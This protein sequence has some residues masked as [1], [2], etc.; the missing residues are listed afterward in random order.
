MSQENEN[1]RF[2]N[3]EAVVRIMKMKTVRTSWRITCYVTWS[4]ETNFILSAIRTLFSSRRWTKMSASI[5][6]SSEACSS[7]LPMSNN[8]TYETDLYPKITPIVRSTPPLKR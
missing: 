4:M 3:E 2:S 8:I 7:R 5:S 1:I 6:R